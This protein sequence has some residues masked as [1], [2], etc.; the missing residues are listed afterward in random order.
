MS[1]PDGG[2]TPFR[3]EKDTNYEGGWR[4][5]CA[6]RWPGVIEPGTVSNDVFSHTDMLPTLAAAAGEPD[7]VQKLETGYRSG[8]K[9][10]KV[11]IDGYNLLPRLKGQAKENPRKG[12]L[13]WSDDGDLM[14]LRVGDWKATFMEQRAH[15]LGV[16]RE[17][18]VS[19]RAPKIYNLRSDPFERG[20]VDASMFYD[21]WMADRAFLLV[22]AQAI[23]GEFLKTFEKFPP[24]QKPS[25][26]SIDQA[27]EKAREGQEQLAGTAAG[28]PH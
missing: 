24:R 19:L 15:G 5:P 26:F 22:P 4:V 17:P 18:L 28:A 20:D 13:Y 8:G 27:L 2:T 9:T 7:V 11:H 25:S 6:I 23:V 12:F 1:W 3:G 16:W 14:A 10:F 21:K